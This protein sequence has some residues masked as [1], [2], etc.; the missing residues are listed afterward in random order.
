MLIDKIVV[1]E[2]CVMGGFV[3]NFSHQQLNEMEGKLNDI[4]VNIHGARHFDDVVEEEYVGLYVEEVNWETVDTRFMIEF[5]DGE[6]ENIRINLLLYVDNKIKFNLE[7][8]LIEKLLRV[9]NVVV[10]GSIDKKKKH[11]GVR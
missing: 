1:V 8:L 5:D 3:Y 9:D 6:E 10:L 7:Q 4:I 11:K 2:M